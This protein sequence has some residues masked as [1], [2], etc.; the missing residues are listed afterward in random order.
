MIY[1]RHWPENNDFYIY[2]KEKGH[3]ELIEKLGYNG[4]GGLIVMDCVE[5]NHTQEVFIIFD[6]FFEFC[7]DFGIKIEFAENFKLTRNMFQSSLVEAF[8]ERDIEEWTRYSAGGHTEFMHGYKGLYENILKS[9]WDKD[10]ETHTERGHYFWLHRWLIQDMR[11][12]GS[13]MPLQVSAYDMRLSQDKDYLIEHTTVEHEVRLDGDIWYRFHPGTGKINVCGLLDRETHPTVIFSLREHNLDYGGEEIRS[14][15]DLQRL[16]PKLMMGNQDR[17]KLRYE[18]DFEY[19]KFMKLY[20]FVTNDTG[21]Y[22]IPTWEFDRNFHNVFQNTLP[23]RIYYVDDDVPNQ[24]KSKNKDFKIHLEKVQPHFDFNDIPKINN[25]KGFA[26]FCK[27]KIQLNRIHLLHEDFNYEDIFEMFYY[28]NTY[29]SLFKN[30]DNFIIYNCEHQS[31]KE[32]SE[33]L[34]GDLPRRL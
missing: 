8:N 14:F 31:W 28:V 27:S 22:K 9:P 16:K 26:I 11:K 29:K 32:N 24:M 2:A 19:C 6:L 5:D 23:L 1:S 25:Y 15:D 13:Y 18:Y 3:G 17:I 7:R 33:P 20:R 34:I 21:D 12:N 4:R 10:Y 30:N